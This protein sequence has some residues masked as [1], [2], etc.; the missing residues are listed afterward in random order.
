M[1][2]RTAILAAT[3][4]LGS[5]SGALAEPA[6][7]YAP[8][9]GHY[10]AVSASAGAAQIERAIEEGTS[11]MSILIRPIARKRLKGVNPM[12][13][14]IR[15]YERAGGLVTDYEG[16]SYAAG[17]DGKPRRNVDPDGSAVMVSY[18]VDGDTL[19]ARYVAADG[20]KSFSFHLTS[21]KEVDVDVTLASDRLPRPI[22][23][24]LDYLRAP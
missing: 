20:E 5:A 23:Y 7:P 9:V 3:I 12:Y 16:R 10:R 19:L 24:K 21:D 13:E 15:I 17:L 18:R 14:S 8:F 11:S 22:S 1:Q 4:G 2:V 6:L